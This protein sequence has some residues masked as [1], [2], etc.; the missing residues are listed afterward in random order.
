MELWGSNPANTII[1][2]EPD[3]PYIQA[4]APY[5]PLSMKTVYCP[6]ETSLNFQ[7]ANK[8]IKELKPGLLVI[9]EAYTIPPM[10]VPN[11]PDL[12]IDQLPVNIY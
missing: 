4:I 10:I 7:Q 6:I 9:P 1:F 11:K 12:V 2:T 3:F 8:L 5:Q